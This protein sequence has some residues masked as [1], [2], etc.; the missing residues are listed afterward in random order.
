MTFIS[1]CEV[2]FS[3]G[4]SVKRHVR[5]KQD[6]EIING[7]CDQAEYINFMNAVDRNNRDSTDFSTSIQTN[8]YF[9]RIFCWGLDRV[10]HT[11]Y[12]VVCFLARKDIGNPE[13]KKYLKHKSA[14]HDFQIDLGFALLNHGI[15]L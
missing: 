7:P 13:W 12:V 8:R 1:N 9:I 5:G 4:Y 3:N 10:V 6:Q 14:R 2:G 11:A 15:W